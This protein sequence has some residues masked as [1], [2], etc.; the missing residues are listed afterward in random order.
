MSIRA[1]KVGN[2]VYKFS[3]KGQMY[4]IDGSAIQEALKTG[5]KVFEVDENNNLGDELGGFES[6]KAAMSALAE[7]LNI[8]VEQEAAA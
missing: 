5:W 7:H 8:S 4:Q 3:Y 1:K 6:K 2:S